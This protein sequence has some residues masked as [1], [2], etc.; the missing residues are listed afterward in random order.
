M[1]EVFKSTWNDKNPRKNNNIIDTS[2][3]QLG[4]LLLRRI[5]AGLKHFM[6]KNHCQHFFPTEKDTPTHYGSD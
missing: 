6:D 3:Q 2:E 1:F 5:K 4:G